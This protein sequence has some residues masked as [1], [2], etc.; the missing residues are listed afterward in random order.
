[1]KANLKNGVFAAAAFITL[2]MGVLLL[3]LGPQNF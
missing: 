3:V 1:M 2:I